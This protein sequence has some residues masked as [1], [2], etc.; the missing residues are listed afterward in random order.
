VPRPLDP[1]LP[2]CRD[3]EHSKITSSGTS[4]S[5]GSRLYRCQ[6]TRGGKPHAFA[7]P[8]PD[9]RHRYRYSN[10]EIAYALWL[11]GRGTLFGEAAADARRK[12]GRPESV[13]GNLTVVWLTRFAP[14]IIAELRPRPRKVGRMLLDA[15]PFNVVD[16]DAA[17][18]PKPGGKLRFAVF[19]AAGQERKGDP[20]VMLAL[21]ASW[22]K[23]KPSWRA[24]LRDLPASA[25]HVISDGEQSIRQTARARWP[26]A[27]LSVS[28]WHVLKR[29]DEILA[30]HELN[31]R[32]KKLYP[33]LRKSLQ[34]KRNWERF[35]ALARKE[36]LPELEKWILDVEAT[37]GPQLSR[38]EKPTSTGAL[39]AALRTIDKHLG[40][41]RGAYRNF[42]RL[43][44]LLG[45]DLLRMNGLDD[46]HEY[47]RIIASA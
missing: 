41:Q 13:D 19:A 16:L 1:D 46:I 12:A 23:D 42:D 21:H 6:P 3:H 28:V 25:D 38:H 47:E 39:E 14:R 27:R 20:L 10:A 34:S 26:Y 44:L 45:L 15:K 9:V 8:A 18:F 35:V 17:G 32:K 37:I 22:K 29:C 43:N 24:F 2:R 7:A 31:S 4:S 40:D 36:R 33:A 30:R 5:R 11:L